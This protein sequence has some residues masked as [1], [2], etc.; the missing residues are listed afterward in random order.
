MLAGAF[1]FPKNTN[2]L[3]ATFQCVG[4]FGSIR[5][6]PLSLQAVNTLTRFIFRSY[7]PPFALTFVISVFVLFMQFLWKWVD[8]LVG[9]G[10]DGS[11]V[12]ELFFYAGLSVV[13]LA[14]PMA[15]LLASLMTFGNLAENY[16]LAALK[17]S[18]M[19]LVRI[20]RPLIIIAV[21]TTVFA[22]VFSNYVLPYTNLKMFSTLYDIRQQKPALNIKDGIFYNEI[23]GYSIRIQKIAPDKVNLE[24]VMI[25]D[26]TDHM[27]NTTLTVA[28]NGKMFMT[29]DKRYLV[30]ELNNGISY[31]EV[32]DQENANATRPFTRVSFK[33]QLLRLD[34]SGFEMQR[35]EEDL[36]KDNDKM[37]NGEQ[38]L[39]Y[40]DTFRM[41]IQNDY[42]SFN[43]SLNNAYFVHTR[44]YWELHDSLKTKPDTGSVFSGFNR[45]ERNRIYEM[46]MNNAR[47]C[48]ANAESKMNEIKAQQRSISR[49]QIEFWRKYTLSFACLLMFFIG[50]PL[51][52][53]IRKGG[54]GMPVVFSII[55]FIIFWVISITFEKLSMKGALPPFI[56]MWMSCVIFIPVAVILTRKATADANLFDIESYLNFFKKLLRRNKDVNKAPDVPENITDL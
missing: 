43:K 25:Y 37:L 10:L 20:M 11:L 9:K 45:E 21:L 31:K 12:A 48:R 23:D 46:A 18:G 2:S 8:E 47:N 35:T 3:I 1:S 52:A 42:N 49:F 51:G 14:I 27:G 40:I 4:E 16:E 56:G 15:V 6:T 34:L 19:S 41:E 44:S 13:P 26:H 7:L 53:I 5:A 33:N 24:G 22:F 32:W 39:S 30:L 29:D 38:L 54:L 50:A 36:F 28:E 55:F 17:S